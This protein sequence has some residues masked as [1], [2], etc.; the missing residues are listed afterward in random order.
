MKLKLNQFD[1]WISTD[2]AEI[3]FGAMKYFDQVIMPEPPE[4][5]KVVRI[6]DSGTP[7][8]TIP[9]ECLNYIKTIKG[10]IREETSRYTTEHQQFHLYENTMFRRKARKVVICSVNGSG[11][12][13]FSIDSLDK[14]NSLLLTS[15]TM[16]ENVMWDLLD[17][18]TRA[19][20]VGKSHGIN[21]QDRYLKEAFV[22]GRLKKRKN[23]GQNTYK[24]T[25]EPKIT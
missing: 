16:S 15:D 20:L 6:L 11:N 4:D 5:V 25:V 24:I 13:W 1:N 17:T 8:R 19:Y 12:H 9:L 22:D 23:R 10:S 7:N 18:M 14:D 21:E 2:P 3:N